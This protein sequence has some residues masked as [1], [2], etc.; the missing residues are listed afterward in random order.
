MPIAR[1]IRR[2]AGPAVLALTLA[3][4]IVAGPATPAQA[5][6][7]PT[8]G[9]TVCHVGPEQVGTVFGGS[10]CQTFGQPLP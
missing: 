10:F 1:S 5:A 3:A 6:S 4:G 2:L 7:S 9:S 8:I